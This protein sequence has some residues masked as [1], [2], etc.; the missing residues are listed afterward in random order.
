MTNPLADLGRRLG[1][2]PER[3]SYKARIILYFPRRPLRVFHADIRMADNTNRALQ[4]GAP[5]R[6]LSFARQLQNI[7]NRLAVMEG[8][9]RVTLVLLLELVFHGC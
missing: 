2:Q 6:P 8:I 9:G 5:L 4:G 1:L 3:Q 7:G